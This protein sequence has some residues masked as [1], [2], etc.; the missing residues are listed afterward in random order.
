[1]H[2]Y[3]IRTMYVVLSRKNRNHIIK[4]EQ[5]IIRGWVISHLKGLVILYL[6][7][8]QIITAGTTAGGQKQLI[9]TTHSQTLGWVRFHQKFIGMT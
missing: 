8:K 7:G 9:R 4:Y 2:I 5:I 1:M 3:H 6:R